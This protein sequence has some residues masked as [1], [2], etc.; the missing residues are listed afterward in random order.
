MGFPQTG[1]YFDCTVLEIID[2]GAKI[3]WLSDSKEE[4]MPLEALHERAKFE[5]KVVTGGRKWAPCTI[6]EDGHKQVKVRFCFDQSE[7]VLPSSDIRDRGVWVPPAVPAYTATKWEFKEQS[8]KDWNDRSNWNK[9]KQQSWPAKAWKKQKTG[10]W[11]EQKKEEPKPVEKAPTG[12]FAFLAQPIA[13]N[14]IPSMFNVLAEPVS[15]TIS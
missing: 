9:R 2:E 11:Q 14:T 3:R 1:G 12:A 7:M 10:K 13:L 4:I 15:C 6:L 5:G 8:W